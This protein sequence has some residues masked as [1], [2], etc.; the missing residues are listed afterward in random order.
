[1]SSRFWDLLVRIGSLVSLYVYSYAWVFGSDNITVQVNN[2]KQSLNLELVFESFFALNIVKTCFT[3]YTPDKENKPVR[4]LQRIC[5]HYLSGQFIWDLLPNAP[6]YLIF[7]VRKADIIMTNLYLVKMLRFPV[8]FQLLNVSNWIQMVQNV[9]R[10]MKARRMKKDN[11]FGEDQAE[12]NNKIGF[13]LMISYFLKGFFLLLTLLQ[14]SFAFGIIWLKFIDNEMHI[15]HD[16]FDPAS[17]PG[18]SEA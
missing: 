11:Q 10:E 13:I 15:L 12:D 2:G 9:I 17:N 18:V 3:D 6:L 4:N 16:W 5:I 7:N 8:A 1:M 14:V